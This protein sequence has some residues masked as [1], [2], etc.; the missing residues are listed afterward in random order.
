MKAVLL[1]V[2]VVAL[3]A[4]GYSQTGLLELN[5]VI[6][7]AVT[8][9]PGYNLIKTAQEISYYR[10]LTYK[11][12]YSPQISLYGN[13]PDFDKEFYGVR[14]P[15]GTIK[16]LPINQNSSNVGVSLTQPVLFT[17]G[18]LSLHTNLSRFDDFTSKAKQYSGTPTYLHLSQPLFGYNNLKWQ[19]RIEP[20]K[21]EEAKYEY[22]QQIETIAWQAVK[23]Y[24]DVLDAQMNIAIASSNQKSSKI[25]LE[26]EKKRLDLGTTTED[27][28]LQL[29]L[30][31]LRNTQEIEK[32]NYQYQVAQL[33][34]KTF[35]GVADSTNLSL[36]LPDKI[37]YFTIDLPGGLAL[38]KKYQPT[39]ASIVRKAT[40]AQRDLAQAKADKHQIQLS[41]SY[42]LN[43]VGN[44]IT[45]IYNNA[46]SQQRFSIGFNIPLV[47][48][49][50]RK[51]RYNM[52]KAAEKLNA[53]NSNFEKSNFILEIST[54]IGNFNLLQ[55][56]IFLAR[57]TDSV[58]DKRYNIA[59]NL[60]KSGSLTIT[61]LSFAQAEKDNSKRNY[62]S[63]LRQYWDAY[64]LLRRLTLYDFEKDESLFTK[65]TF[66][67]LHD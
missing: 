65:N 4:T 5:D 16:F 48:W 66:G 22:A 42:G 46:Y 45:E 64:Y 2:S 28:L 30:Q 25:N 36:A 37:L 17:G 62:L 35:L 12:E 33:N 20:L 67:I 21:F 15:N 40:E 59:Y 6:R 26:I 27:K 14:Q 3:H 13:I 63:A 43:N 50:R 60:Y 39:L 34:L 18:E 56:N 54:L 52:A 49:G 10:F 44:K 58:A 47:D 11:S 57:K 31:F 61:D 19:K 55:N 1:I 8:H 38:A 53:S 32:Y 41:A 9:S 51:A 7:L 24:F 29:E 23:Y